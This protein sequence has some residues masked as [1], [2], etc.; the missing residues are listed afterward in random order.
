M[1][2][3]IKFSSLLVAMDRSVKCYYREAEI[4]NG[5]QTV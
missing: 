4:R 5:K 2:R 1:L 3:A